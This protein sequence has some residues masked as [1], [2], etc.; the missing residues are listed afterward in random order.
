MPKTNYYAPAGGHAPQTQLLTDRA[1]FT[2]AYAV[3]PKGVIQ[4][5][6]TSK[7]PFWSD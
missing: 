2:D 1:V 6:V 3:I 7:L 4:D 5:I